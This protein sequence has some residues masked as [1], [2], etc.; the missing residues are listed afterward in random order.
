MK[1]HHFFYFA[2]ILSIG[3]IAC[4]R[5]PV[6]SSALDIP[7]TSQKF[8]P[9]DTSLEK[10]ELDKEALKNIL[11]AEQYNVICEEGTERSFGNSYYDNK[12]EGYYYC[13]ACGLPLFTSETKYESGSG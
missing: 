10:V 12:E 3:L 11:S 5:S 1:K 2:L 6:Q 4:D 7:A 8:T 9:K 13:A